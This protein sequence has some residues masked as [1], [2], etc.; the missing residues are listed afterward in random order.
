MPIELVDGPWRAKG[1]EALHYRVRNEDGTFLCRI[2]DLAIFD[3]YEL[4][5][6]EYTY[7]QAFEKCVDD[8]LRRTDKLLP[9]LS[10]VPDGEPDVIIKR[11]SAMP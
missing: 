8:I 11:G 10:D 9:P 7:E 1:L 4:S 6:E 5:Y 2:T 3:D